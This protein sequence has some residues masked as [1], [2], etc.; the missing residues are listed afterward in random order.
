MS[1]VRFCLWKRIT[2]MPDLKLGLAWGHL[3]GSF[4][5]FLFSLPIKPI[6]EYTLYLSL[7][8]HW[9]MRFYLCRAGRE[10]IKQQVLSKGKVSAMSN[11]GTEK[12]ESQRL[13][14]GGVKGQRTK[15]SRKWWKREKVKGSQLIWYVFFLE[16]RGSG[17]AGLQPR[18]MFHLLFTF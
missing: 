17:E 12:L 11:D 3:S 8:F 15:G 13:E 2:V 14:W 9:E 18:K 4:N 7:R 10:S 1:W 5:N 16:I 6:P